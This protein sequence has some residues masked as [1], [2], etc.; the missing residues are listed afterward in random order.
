[1]L[2]LQKELYNCVNSLLPSGDGHIE[3]KAVIEKN[4]PGWVFVDS[5]QD[6]Q[7]A[8]IWN[9]GNGGFYLLG[10]DIARNKDEINSF[11]D[12]IIKPKLM[13]IGENYLEISSAPPISN[14]DME[15]VLN[16]RNYDSWEQSV[17]L[18]KHKGIIALTDNAYLNDI[19]EVLENQDI[20]M[21]FVE[22]NILNYWDSIDTFLTKADGFC[23]IVDNV[24]VSLALTGWV[25]GNVH[26]IIIDTIEEHRKKGFAK[27]CSSA[28]INRYLEKG[29]VP[30]W[31]CEKSNIASAKIAEGFGFIKLYD[32]LCYGFW[33]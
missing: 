15:N 1:M 12:S 18:Y 25:A 14:C 2:E 13:S 21:S 7:M 3:I 27:I 4:N 26:E 19:K 17:Y 11:I 30:Y 10:N 33:L 16:S 8:I 28:L 24:A 20:N 9:K 31:E 29:Y 22:N 32:Y 6:P 23:I 5:Q